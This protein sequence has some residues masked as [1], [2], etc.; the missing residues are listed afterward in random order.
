M[1]FNTTVLIL[2]DCLSDIEQ[3]PDFG[4]K[5][6]RAVQRLS[7]GDKVDISSGH[8][9]NAATVVETHHADGYKLILV[10]GNT[11]FDLGY[12]GSIRDLDP[13]KNEDLREILN[14][15]LRD[16][17]MRV[18]TK[19]T[20]DFPFGRARFPKVKRSGAMP[21]MVETEREF[22]IR[23]MIKIDTQSDWY[24]RMEKMVEGGKRI[25]AIKHLRANAGLGLA[26]SKHFLDQWYPYN[27]AGEAVTVQN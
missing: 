22:P 21:L 2:N 12:V 13:G 26:E 16:R 24:K 27:E 7:L 23:E 19:P 17:G 6:S 14:T 4:Q 9:G 15:L 3:D 18:V 25:E 5:I 20:N 10:G 1:G 11:A 8:S